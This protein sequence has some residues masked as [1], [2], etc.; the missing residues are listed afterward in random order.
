M[1]EAR[2]TR[3]SAVELRNAVLAAE[4]SQRGF[5]VTGNEIYLAPYDSAKAKRNASS[6]RSS[7]RSSATRDSEAML[8]APLHRVAEKIAEMDQTIA[9]KND[10][11]TTK[12]SRCSRTNR[13]KSLMDEANVFLSG[14]IQSADERLTAGVGEQRANASCCAGFRSSAAS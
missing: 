11:A 14:I 3:S 7:A 6:T 8:R 4:S 13:G 2:D 10:R 1:I 5:I 9:L 12:R